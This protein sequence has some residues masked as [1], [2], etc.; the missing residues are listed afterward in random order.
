MKKLMIALAAVACAAAVQAS[1]VRWNINNIYGVNDKGAGQTTSD[2]RPAAG[3]YYVMCMLASEMSLAD[4]KTAIANNDIA[5]IAAKATYKGTT[6]GTGAF[7]SSY[8]DGGWKGGDT[9]QIYAVV[10]NASS[11]DKATYAVASSAVSAYEYADSAEDKSLSHNMKTATQG[12]WTAVGGS[13]PVPEP[14]SGLLLLLGV[15]GLALR[16][17]RA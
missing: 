16:R 9:V 4:A 15:A 8:Y 6:T 10:L 14:T 13:S 7:A 5:S 17:R 12:T 2:S 1:T 3:A 11:I